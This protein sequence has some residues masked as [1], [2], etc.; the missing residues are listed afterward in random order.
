VATRGA[1][2]KAKGGYQPKIWRRTHRAGKKLVFGGPASRM[3]L[4]LDIVCVVERWVAEFASHGLESLWIMLLHLI[5]GSSALV[6]WGKCG[7]EI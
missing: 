6:G 4:L 7:W 3:T 1:K 5:V 2:T